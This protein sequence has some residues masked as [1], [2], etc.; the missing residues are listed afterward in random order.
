MKAIVQKLRRYRA[1]SERAEQPFG[2]C[3]ALRDAR[4]LDAYRRMA[5]LGVTELITVPWLFYDAD[6]ASCQQKCDGIRRFGDE[7]V[8]RL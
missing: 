5:D 8:A 7:V 4:D 3:C 6:P 2:L 1:D